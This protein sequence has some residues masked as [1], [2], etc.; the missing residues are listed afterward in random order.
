R[1]RER[2]PRRR[3]PAQSTRS[4]HTNSRRLHS[5]ARGTAGARLCFDSAESLLREACQKRGW[6]ALE[7]PS[8]REPALRALCYCITLAAAAIRS[9]GIWTFIR[10]A[11]LRLTMIV[12]SL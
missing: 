3:T 9:A 5:F 11:A 8:T 7:E 4:A 10:C 1:R 12:S 2:G 6:K